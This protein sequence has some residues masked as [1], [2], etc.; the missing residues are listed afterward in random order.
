M[1]WP[2]L[3]FLTTARSTTLASSLK[4]NSPP[5]WASSVMCSVGRVRS[6]YFNSAL[7]DSDP[8]NTIGTDSHSWHFDWIRSE[9][10][11]P[12]SLHTLNYTDCPQ[13]RKQKKS[14][15]KVDSLT[16]P[17]PGKLDPALLGGSSV[18]MMSK[19]REAGILGHSVS[20]LPSART[21]LPF[22]YCSPETT[23]CRDSDLTLS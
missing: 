10:L 12:S 15:V 21:V 8:N 19:E 18:D 14:L 2:F 23:D 9:T 3:P 4:P 7:L 13:R 11:F 16:F 22:K 17:H 6:F 1:L 20:Q 5:L